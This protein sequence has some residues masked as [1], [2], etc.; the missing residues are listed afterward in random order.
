MVFIGPGPDDI[1]IT[2]EALRYLRSLGNTA[3]ISDITLF[4]QLLPGPYALVKQV[5]REVWKLVDD[6]NGT[7]MATLRPLSNFALP[8]RIIS[9]AAH[10]SP[11][12]GLRVL[13]DDNIHL[14]GIKTAMGNKAVDNTRPPPTKS[15][16]CIQ[17]LVDLG[18]VVAGKTRMTPFGNLESP[19]ESP[20]CQTPRNPR[21][22][23][24]QLPGEGGSGGAC[25]IAAYEWLDIA[26]V[27]DTWG[28][29]TRCSL[30][31]GCFS[32]RP[33]IGV[34]P[35]EGAEPSW[36]TPG[37]L[38]RDMQKFRDFADDWL[39]LDALDNRKPFSSII[40]PI[41]FWNMMDPAQTE[42]ARTFAQ[43]M[44]RVLAVTLE[45]ISFEQMWATSPPSEACGLWMEAFMN[46]ATAAMA[47]EVY[48]SNDEFCV[49]GQELFHEAPNTGVPNESLWSI[50]KT[51]CKAYRDAGFQRIDIYKKWFYDTIFAGNRSNALIVLPLETISQIHWDK[52]PT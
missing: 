23:G 28:S 52:P 17:Q 48:H 26:I 32:L 18:V 1:E 11:I 41:D 5:L 35:T 38:A 9:E 8:S 10:S 2:P 6:S 27:T 22:D 43:V 34:L 39:D 45:D 14:K 36:D 47:Y 44:R 15:A 40:W 7:C 42:I 30:R 25:A 21:G 4:P 31:C 46:P 24:Y 16:E 19:T 20:G 51:V 49:E 37:I 29:L 33:S 3:T 12:G 13:V 50:G